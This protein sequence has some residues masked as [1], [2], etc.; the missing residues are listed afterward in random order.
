MDSDINRRQFL[1]QANCA[2]VGTASLF[3]TLFSLRLT[4]GA[5]SGTP[6]SGYKALVC[7]FLNGGNDS[8]NMLVPVG[9]ANSAVPDYGP[10][11]QYSAVRTSLALPRNQLLPISSAGQPFPDFGIH[12]NLPYLRNLYNQGNAAFVANVGTL[13][14]PTTLSQFTSK[15]AKLPVGLFSHSDESIHWQTL[16]PQVRGAGP[17]GWAGRVAECMSQANASGNISMNLSLS[18]NN[19]FQVGNKSVPYITS[20]SGVVLPDLYNSSNPSDPATMAVDS[21]LGETYR[22]LYEKTLA[23]GNRRSIDTSVAFASAIG[24]LSTTEEFPNTQVGSRLKVISTVIKARG[25]LG[26][27]RQI[28]FVERGGWD[29]HNDVLGPQQD[30]FTEVNAAI[31]SFWLEMGH[32][33]LQNDVVLFTASDFG[34]TLTS[35][36][37]GSDHAWGGNHFV[38]GGDVN[39]GKIY[40]DFPEL[41]TGSNLD[42]GRGRLLPTTP[43]DKYCAELASW[44]GVPPSE[45]ETVFPNSTNFFN[46]LTT[47]HPLG[48]F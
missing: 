38:I 23:T 33:D 37:T 1:K 29:H 2:A 13:V 46:P 21:I 22:N 11:N 42:L 5:A 27:N 18:G 40:G 26:M 31:Q 16:V 41:A 20:P 9:D 39:G 24:G 10:Y 44:Y 7:L 17:R 3:S 32:L 47:P 4:A 35:N 43:V 36:G 48:I 14:E 45:L 19:V 15:T 30:L 6:L 25:T 34:R 12:P 8:Y 28:F